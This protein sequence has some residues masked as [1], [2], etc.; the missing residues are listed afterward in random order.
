MCIPPGIL[1][2]S[3]DDLERETK[4][5]ILL[6]SLINSEVVLILVLRVN[7]ETLQLS[8]LVFHAPREVNPFMKAGVMV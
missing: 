8:S 6:I 1:N 7:K 4:V 5:Y 2:K 3:P